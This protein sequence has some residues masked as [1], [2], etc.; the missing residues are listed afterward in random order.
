[1]RT[2]RLKEEKKK[3]S[4]DQLRSRKSGKNEGWHE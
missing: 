4:A 2:E 1:M 3:T